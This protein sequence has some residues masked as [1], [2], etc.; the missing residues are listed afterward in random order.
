[1]ASPMA[2]TRGVG[3]SGAPYTMVNTRRIDGRTRSLPLADDEDIPDREIDFPLD[4][5]GALK[6]TGQS[7]RF[8]YGF[9]AA[10]EED[11]NI[12]GTKA[13]V[14]VKATQA[15]SNYGLAR[16][17]NEDSKNGAYLA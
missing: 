9:F 12:R 15:D 11:I 14:P 2:D 16:L 3:D 4:L 8:Q 13:G 1:M 6:V 5:L 10:F 7:G 17:I